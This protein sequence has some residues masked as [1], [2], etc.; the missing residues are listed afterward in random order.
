MY[1]YLKKHGVF[2]IE[3]IP[4]IMS[5]LAY[6][7]NDYKVFDQ[8][9]HF[10]EKHYFCTS[11]QGEYYALCSDF[12]MTD[13]FE[14][15]QDALWVVLVNDGWFKRGP[16]SLLLRNAACLRSWLAKKPILYVSYAYAEFFN[17]GFSWP[18]QKSVII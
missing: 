5:W 17:Y 16:I 10:C 13:T 15:T 4:W 14:K 12:H 7:W 1:L 8:S 3:R 2:F 18:L 9:A 11:E 6:F